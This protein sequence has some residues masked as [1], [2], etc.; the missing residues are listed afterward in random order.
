M[1]TAAIISQLSEG[2]TE[3]MRSAFRHGGVAWSK[4]PACHRRLE[5]AG[6]VTRGK[7]TEN[8]SVTAYLTDI[9]KTVMKRLRQR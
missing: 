7:D 8:G 6:L 5:T 4:R 3:V 2:D 1:D 9:G